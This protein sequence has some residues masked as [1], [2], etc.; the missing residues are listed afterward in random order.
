MR[1]ILNEYKDSNGERIKRGLVIYGDNNSIGKE[2]KKIIL[3]F[4]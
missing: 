4:I 2:G 1:K 3:V